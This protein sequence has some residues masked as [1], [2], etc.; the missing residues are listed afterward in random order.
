[1]PIEVEI[2]P[3]GY[4]VTSYRSVTD[5][6]ALAR[7]AALA[8]PAIEACGGR[9]LARGEA[10]QAY[11]DGVHQRIVI[12]EF[13]SVE[14]AMAAYQSPEYQAALAVLGNS[15]ERDVRIVSGV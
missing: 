14:R 4:W 6:A 5:E 2:V 10:A 13:E 15:A 12:I 11:E 1:M 7:Y 3:K 9:F 8:G